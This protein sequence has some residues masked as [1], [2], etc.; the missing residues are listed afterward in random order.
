LFLDGADD[1]SGNVPNNVPEQIVNNWLSWAFLPDWEARV[2][3]QWVGQVYANDANTEKRPDFTVVNLGLDYQVDDKSTISLRGFNVFDEVY[4]TQGGD[5]SWQLAPPRSA[6]I[7][8]R[9][10]Y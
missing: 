9:I 7:S 1:Y 8:Y 2:G 10:R 5:A 6:E 3:V 4:A